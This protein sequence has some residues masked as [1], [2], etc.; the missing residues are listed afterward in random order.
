MNLKPRT[1]LI[2][3]G[4]NL[5]YYCEKFNSMSTE[6]RNAQVAKLKICINCLR[7]SHFAHQWKPG[8]CRLCKRKHN[9]L[10]HKANVSKPTKP[11]A[12]ENSPNSNSTCNPIVL[13]IILYR[14]PSSA[15]NSN[16]KIASK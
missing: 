8:P 11:I 13:S 4:D 2:C 15:I 12:V 1:C 9:T 14:E 3:E 10:L 7:G 6:D 5:I 16:S